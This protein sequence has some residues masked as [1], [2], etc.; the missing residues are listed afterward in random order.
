M[1]EADKAYVRLGVKSYD[2]LNTKASKEEVD[3]AKCTKFLEVVIPPGKTVRL[4]RKYDQAIR[5]VSP[6]TGQACAGLCPWL[7]KKGEE[8]VVVA[9]VFDFRAAIAMEEADQMMEKATQAEKLERAAAI[10]R[11]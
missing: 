2:Q 11:K 10:L 7:K 3:A 5:W 1:D 6:R 4:P 8:T 9:K